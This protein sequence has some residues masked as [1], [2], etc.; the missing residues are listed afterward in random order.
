MGISF[1]IVHNWPNEMTKYRQKRVRR[2]TK[3]LLV[4]SRVVDFH[5]STVYR[6]TIRLIFVASARLKVSNCRKSGTRPITFLNLPEENLRRKNFILS[7]AIMSCQ[8]EI[9]LIQIS[10]NK[11]F[12]Q[13]EFFF[14]DFTTF[15]IPNFYYKSEFLYH[16]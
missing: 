4:F 9:I 11:L 7:T 2:F 14:R 6:A 12:F 15:Y 16:K 8:R 1:K 3:F 13:D 5:A 10:L